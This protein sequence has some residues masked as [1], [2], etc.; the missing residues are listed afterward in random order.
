MIK[1]WSFSKT[2][3]ILKKKL[4]S[5]IVSQNH[6]LNQILGVH[7]LGEFLLWILVE[8]L[9]GSDGSKNTPVGS[10]EEQEISEA[11]IYNGIPNFPLILLILPSELVYFPVHRHPVF[12]LGSLLWNIALGRI[13]WNIALSGRG[14]LR[15]NSSCITL[16]CMA[17][18]KPFLNIH[19]H[20][21]LS[22][23]GFA[24]GY[25]VKF[26]PSPSGTFSDKGLHLTV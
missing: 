9:T 18:Q 12:T 24:L 16:P 20:F 6:Y 13:R 23:L 11:C 1:N 25:T 14:I 8:W 17:T 2:T 3:D 5:V 7:P 4:R 22:I 15:I 26:S 21:I 10:L 19:K